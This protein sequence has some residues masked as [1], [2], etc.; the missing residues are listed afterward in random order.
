MKEVFDTQ[1]WENREKSMPQK[2]LLA[3]GIGKMEEK[4]CLE[5]NFGHAEL[6]KWRKRHAA[7]E[8][9]D[10]QNWENREKSVP[11]KKLLTRRIGKMEEKACR[12]RNF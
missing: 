11:R 10:T 4:A 3:R 9:F 8:T 12:E 2:K 6:G 1:N 5:R 7:K